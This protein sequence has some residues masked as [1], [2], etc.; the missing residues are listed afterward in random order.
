MSLA[1]IKDVEF[2]KVDEE[3]VESEIFSMYREMTGRTPAQGD[4]IRLFLNFVTNYVVFLKNELN[5]TAKKNLLKYADGNFL[6][7][8]GILWGV[9]RIIAQKA[10]TTIKIELSRQREVATLIPKGVRISPAE[11]IFFETEE[12]IIINSSETEATV[13]AA[14]T[15][16]GEIGN[17]YA[18]GEINRIVD[19]IGYVKSM[20]NITKSSG[21]SE[22]EDDESL[23]ER[24]Y[25]SP[26][27]LS[28][29]GPKQAY[30]WRVKSLN[31]NIIDVG[32]DSPNP[33]EV[34]IIPLMKGGAMPSSEML[35]TIEEELN[36]DDK[37]PLTD[38]IVVESPTQINYEIVLEYW[39]TSE[40]KASTLDEVYQEVQ[41]YILWQKSA[42]GRDINDSELIKRIK[43]LSGV[44]R[45]KIIE[46]GFR[47]LQMNE[48]AVCLNYELTYKGREE[49]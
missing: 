11:D 29:A 48:L 47:E 45:V 38:K 39:L 18:I 26:E 41:K 28:I 19:P 44:K 15:E 23:R 20:T 17:D 31:A 43:E 34:R 4:P 40:A 16:T 24:I 9:K 46:P 8:L 33:G 3:Q 32:V 35:S 42:L 36:E 14:C 25:E 13:K 21:G 7:N 30:K 12:D 6:E 10:E 1:E 22:I 27:A 2:V 5:E 37:R 49:D